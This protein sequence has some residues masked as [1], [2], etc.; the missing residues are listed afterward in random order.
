MKS[1]AELR[2]SKRWRFAKSSARGAA[3]EAAQA[4]GKTEVTDRGRP[5][6]GS[7]PDCGPVRH[8]PVLLQEVLRAIC[9]G[10]AERFIDGTYA[11]GGYSSGI[12]D[13]GDCRV[14]ALDRDP[15]AIA[16]GRGLDPPMAD[17]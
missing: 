6:E 10:A 7:S 1:F 15:A 3:D 5:V 13:A 9:P 11:A 8:I 2:A 4:K 16:A 17:G 12:L 14:L